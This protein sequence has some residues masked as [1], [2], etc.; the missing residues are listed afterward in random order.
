MD[1]DVVYTWVDGTDLAWL[2]RRECYISEIPDMQ[3][4]EEN[5]D[6]R[7]IQSNE[8]MYSLYFLRKNAPWVRN[9]YLVTDQQT[10]DWLTEDKLSLLGVEIVDHKDLFL[11]YCSALPTFNS[12]TIETMLYRVPGLSEKFI[13]FNDD[14]LLVNKVDVSDFFI[15]SALVVRGRR[16]FTIKILD[17]AY[18]NWLKL[19]GRSNESGG[20]VG[21]MPSSTALP[22]FSYIELAHAGHGAY[23]Q[24]FKQFIDHAFISKNIFYRF[25]DKKQISP[26][27]YVLNWAKQNRKI[28]RI[29]NDWKCFYT[30]DIVDRTGRLRFD[31]KEFEGV[32]FA[33]FN[34]LS[35]LDK[36]ALKELQ[37]L[38][39]IY[40]D[41]C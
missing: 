8:L 12:M 15:G 25:R 3:S 29:D 38:L 27:S 22:G 32:K 31:L 40:L 19:L 26:F 37:S 4:G 10:P 1:I 11:E 30:N 39:S 24:D 9:I 20:Y 33:C 35:K 16:R 13:Y 14:I 6:S 28:Y 23:R 41:R 2:E 34:D 18:K 7:Y 36:H 5:S 17:K 21:R